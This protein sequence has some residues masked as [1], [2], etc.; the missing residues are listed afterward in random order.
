MENRFKE[1]VALEQVKA[2]CQAFLDSNKATVDAGKS[3]LRGA[4]ILN[5]AT[6]IAIMYAK[7]TA[8]YS[9]AF[10]FGLGALLA[11]L[12]T[13]AAYIISYS[14]AETWSGYLVLQNLSQEDLSHLSKRIN[15]WKLFAI[16]CT[17]LSYILFFASLC[18]AYFLL[19]EI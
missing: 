11:C 4:F 7:V 12:A 8:L 15:K 3:A 10:Y 9:V 19:L 5:G 18:Y 2:R 1:E 17:V 13:G 16:V 14:I 6:A